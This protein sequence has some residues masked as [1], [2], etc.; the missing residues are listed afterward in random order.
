MRSKD[1]RGS[2]CPTDLSPPPCSHIIC[3]GHFL[4]KQNSGRT[5]DRKEEIEGER[6]R[7]NFGS[8]FV[9]PSVGSGKERGQK[10]ISASPARTSFFPQRAS[11][12]AAE[13]VTEVERKQ[14]NGAA[15]DCL[16]SSSW[17][18]LSPDTASLSRLR[19][20]DHEIPQGSAKLPFPGCRSFDLALPGYGCS[21]LPSRSDNLD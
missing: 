10:S 8:V 20:Y 13:G 16:G 15:A 17:A 1:R 19:S 21:I 3:I 11:E 7:G 14:S 4:G 2:K 18:H 9:R 6:E 5:T 12:R